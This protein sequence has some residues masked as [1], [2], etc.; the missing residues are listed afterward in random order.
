M[1]IYFMLS[2][3]NRVLCVLVCFEDWNSWIK[4]L[5]CH[6]KH[7]GWRHLYPGVESDHEQDLGHCNQLEPW[8][9]TPALCCMQGYIQ[10][11][12]QNSFCLTSNSLFFSTISFK[13]LPISLKSLLKSVILSSVILMSTSKH[14]LFLSLVTSGCTGCDSSAANTLRLQS[15]ASWK[16][17][18]SEVK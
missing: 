8:E 18:N 10:H 4:A 1:Q 12:L 9:R 7:R 13:A 14:S 6:K 15:Y 17:D 3:Q 16:S 2:L 11:G 5:Q